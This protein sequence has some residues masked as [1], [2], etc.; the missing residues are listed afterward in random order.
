[1]NKMILIMRTKLV[2]IM[3]RKG[4]IRKFLNLYVSYGACG[5]NKEHRAAVIRKISMNNQANA[6]LISEG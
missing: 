5:I 4:C 3:H 6:V 2:F 1:M